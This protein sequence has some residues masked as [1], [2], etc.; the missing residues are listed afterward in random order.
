[1]LWC[2]IYSESADR[3]FWMMNGVPDDN[4]EAALQ[5]CADA[6]K[7][8]PAWLFKVQALS[9]ELFEAIARSC[10]ESHTRLVLTALDTLL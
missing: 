3:P 10:V 2:L 7:A 8:H 1:M 5:R 6:Q 9:P 4:R